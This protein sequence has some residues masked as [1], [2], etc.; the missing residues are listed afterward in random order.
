M[1]VTPERGN[2]EVAIPE[3]LFAEYPNSVRK[4]IFFIIRGL[5]KLRMVPRHRPRCCGIRQ[6]FIKLQ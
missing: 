5:R 1:A 4:S 6:N 3:S 2:E